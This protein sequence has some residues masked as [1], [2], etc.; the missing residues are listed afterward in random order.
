MEGLE[1][2][3][4]SDRK[5]DFFLSLFIYFEREHT[6]VHVYA[7]E[8]GRESRRER[9]SHAGS[10]PSEEPDSGLDLMMVRS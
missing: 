1:V 10:M 3:P 4:W 9:E 5:Q 7:W 2:G 6:H 8:R